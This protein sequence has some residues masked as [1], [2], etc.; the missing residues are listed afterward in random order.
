MKRSELEGLVGRIRQTRRA[1]AAGEMADGD[2]AGADD[3]QLDRMARSS[4][5]WLT[6]SVCWKGF[7]IRSTGS[8][9][10]TRG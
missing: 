7:R 8:P 9:S 4:D 2:A 6:W 3:P 5:A 1:N 10:V